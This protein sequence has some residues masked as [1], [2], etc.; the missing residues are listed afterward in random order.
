M[1]KGRS[2]VSYFSFFVVFSNHPPFFEAKLKR[3]HKPGDINLSCTWFIVHTSGNLKIYCSSIY[4]F[5]IRI[6]P[7]QVG[8]KL[9]RA[10]YWCLSSRLFEIL[11]FENQGKVG[12][13]RLAHKD[14]ALSEF[15]SILT[16]A[17]D[18]N[19]IAQSISKT[20]PQ[21]LPIFRSK[22]GSKVDVVPC[23]TFAN[24]Q[25]KKKK[26][27]VYGSKAAIGEI[28]TTTTT[29]TKTTTTTTITTTTKTS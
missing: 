21:V 6:W 24:F 27:T 9:L 12:L 18:I 7:T 14:K 26:K 28:A 25:E 11:Q 8:T 29:T 20:C 10:F 2:Q 23:A 19:E 5:W 22:A 4:Y 15:Y 16:F 1:K 17:H 3:E 13:E